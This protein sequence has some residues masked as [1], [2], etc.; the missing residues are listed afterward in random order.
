MKIGML[1]LPLHTNYGGILQ[2]YALQ[3][4]LKSQKHDAQFV[5]TGNCSPRRLSLKVRYLIYIKRFLLRYIFGKDIEVCPDYLRVKEYKYL[6]KHTQYFIDKYISFDEN[7]K[8]HPETLDVAI[9]GSDQVWRKLYIG[10]SYSNYFLD[11][12]GEDSTIK[13]IAFSASFGVDTWDFTEEETAICAQL[14]K[15]F[16]LITVR[17][18]SAIPLCEKYLGVEAS[19]TLDPTLLLER[20]DYIN[21]VEQENEGKRP[22]NL[23]YYILDETAEK[24]DLVNRVA[25]DLHLTPFKTMPEKQLEKFIYEE[26]YC[27][28]PVTAWL[29]S[30]MDAEFVVTDSFHG[31]VFSIIFNKPFLAIGNKDRGM[32]RF[33]SL[34][35]LFQ[36]ED[37]LVYLEDGKYTYSPNEID[38]QKVNAIHADWK[39]KSINLLKDALKNE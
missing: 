19:L 20:S 15:K 4:L 35:K 7:L 12:L 2:A 24:K 37:R 22:G 34:L 32:S 13:R 33:N 3:T 14:A 30:F 39:I 10:D 16:D 27:Y 31:C 28:P 8:I 6:S 36:L 38:W 9:V 5:S 21:L 11:F 26:K 29:R 1:T 18:D 25:E 17:E 23:F